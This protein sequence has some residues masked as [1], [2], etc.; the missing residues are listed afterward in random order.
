MPI[1][2]TPI[3]N[4]LKRLQNEDATKWSSWNLRA[5][6]Q[7]SWLYTAPYVQDWQGPE[8]LEEHLALATADEPLGYF[9]HFR[10]QMVSR[11]RWHADAAQLLFLPRVIPGGHWQPCRGYFRVNAFGREWFTFRSFASHEKAGQIPARNSIITV[12]GDGQDYTTARLLHYEGASENPDAVFDIC[13]ADLTGSYRFSGNAWPTLNSNRVKPDERAWFDAPKGLLPHSL[14]AFRPKGDGPMTA[15]E[16]D[17]ETVPLGQKDFEYAYR[18]AVFARGEH[19]YILILGDLK[20]DGEVRDYTWNAALPKDLMKPEAHRIQGDRALITDP[21]D[22]SRRLFVQMLSHE[23][24][25]AFTLAPAYSRHEKKETDLINLCFKSR[26]AGQRFYTLIYPH[27]EG[28]P[29]PKVEV[30]GDRYR[31]AI[32]NQVGELTVSRDATGRQQ[33]RVRRR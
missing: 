25:G 26:S 12:D 16:I 4:Y 23:G 21:A 29:Q 27:R 1:R 11:D 13:T 8:D 3:L 10:G 5:F 7:E 24:E 15:E 31:I 2:R 22:P 6:G 28:A 19:P 20:K 17:L 9:S 30:S 18:T 32:G 33:V 14:N